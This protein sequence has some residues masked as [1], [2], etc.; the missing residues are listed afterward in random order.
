VSSLVLAFGEDRALWTHHATTTKWTQSDEAG[1]Y[2]VSGLRPGNY[3]VVALQPSSGSSMMNNTN[4]GYWE[5]LAKQ[6]TPVTIGDD[7]RKVLNLKLAS[8]PDR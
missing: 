6:A 4:T 5:S 7:E 2:T 1:K 8:E 3:L